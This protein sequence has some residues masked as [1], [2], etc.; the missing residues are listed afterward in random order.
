MSDPSTDLEGAAYYARQDAEPV[1]RPSPEEYEEP[2][3]DTR[4]RCAVC[5]E[6]TEIRRD[7]WV[8][9]HAC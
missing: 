6:L 3:R 7:G 5:G 9:R 4:P 1:D 8:R 2:Q